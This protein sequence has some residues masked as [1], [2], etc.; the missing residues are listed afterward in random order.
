MAGAREL[1][2][3]RKAGRTGADDRDAPAG[4]CRRRLRADPALF[5]G[6]VDDCVLDRFDADGV[7]ID[8]QRAGSSHGAGHTRPVNSGK[9]LVECSVSIALRQSCR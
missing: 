2:R 7:V 5:P 4:S 9:L 1:L 3:T 6:L 8:A